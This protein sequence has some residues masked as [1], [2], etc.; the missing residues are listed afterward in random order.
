[1]RAQDKCPHP[2][3]RVEVWNPDKNE[4]LVF[5]TNNLRFG[6]STVAAIYKE[7]WQVE[8]LFKALKQNLKIKTFVG[9][10]PNAVK[11]QVWSALIAILL[12]RYL[13]LKS[14]FGWSLSNLVALLRMNLFTYRDLWAWLDDPFGTPP[15]D[16]A[17]IRQEVLALG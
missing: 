4:T 1:V 9:T 12:L 15:P 8:L 7:R 17:T 6:A 16:E 5:L 3:R 2:L 10:S 11:I 13:Q 14:R